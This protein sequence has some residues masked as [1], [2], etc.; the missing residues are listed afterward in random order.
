MTVCRSPLHACVRA[1]DQSANLWWQLRHGLLPQRNLPDVAVVMI[2]TN[3]L[4][5]L[6]ACS[7]WEADDLAAVPGISSRC[8]SV[9]ARQVLMG[10]I[11][12]N[13][14]A[15]ACRPPAFASMAAGRGWR[16][17]LWC[18][19]LNISAL[20]GC[21]LET[22]IGMRVLMVSLTALKLKTLWG[23]SIRG[24]APLRR[25]LVLINPLKTPNTNPCGVPGSATP[26][27]CCGARCRARTSC[28]WAS[29]RAAAGPWAPTSTSGPTG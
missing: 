29:C 7:R 17:S 27:R 26:S 2:G 10:D 12:S 16:R 3:D 25:A 4:G 5:F 23:A 20:L 13:V 28:C 18:R 24:V 21:Q 19:R 1:G 8:A 6:D 22:Q 9:L 15:C 14:L 11:I